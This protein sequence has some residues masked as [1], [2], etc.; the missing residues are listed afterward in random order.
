MFR[1]LWGAVRQR[2]KNSVKLGLHAKT[3]AVRAAKCF[4]RAYS[5]VNNGDLTWTCKYVQGYS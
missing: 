2:G 1:H 4:G 3:Q 5:T